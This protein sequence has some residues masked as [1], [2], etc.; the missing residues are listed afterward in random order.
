M[1][2]TIKNKRQHKYTNK[3]NKKKYKKNNKKSYKK[4]KK[5]GHK[6][7]K[8]LLKLA[9]KSR[10][11]PVKEGF[12]EVDNLKQITKKI[13]S[14]TQDKIIEKRI[15]NINLDNSQPIDFAS[16]DQLILTQK[17]PDTTRVETEKENLDRILDEKT[18]GEELNRNMEIYAKKLN[19]ENLSDEEYNKRIKKYY[20]EQLDNALKKNKE[21]SKKIKKITNFD[22]N[23]KKIK[24]SDVKKNIINISDIINKKMMARL[25]E[26][27]NNIDPNLSDEEK[28]IQL[29]DESMK[30]MK[31]YQQKFT[32]FAKKNN[33]ETKKNIIMSKKFKEFVETL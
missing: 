22:E 23:V 16:S 2:K 6:Y 28:N 1:S 26:I 14:N 12:A 19:K 32:E 13:K 20:D 33:S 15:K 3:Y 10:L 8:K 27:K 25:E 24:D 21:Y 30:L 5:G 7:T 31:S 29:R 4:H 18:I 9:S 17:K 11:P